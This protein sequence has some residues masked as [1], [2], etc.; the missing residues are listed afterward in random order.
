MRKISFIKKKKKKNCPD[1]LNYYTTQG[2]AQLE[3]SNN[4]VKVGVEP[5]C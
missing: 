1:S 4:I 2:R 5:T 3:H